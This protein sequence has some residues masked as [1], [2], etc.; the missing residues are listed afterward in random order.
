MCLWS[1]DGYVGSSEADVGAPNLGHLLSHP[2]GPLHSSISE[3]V[4]LSLQWHSASLSSCIA[5][6]FME[7]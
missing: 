7:I 4:L 2:S 3:S 6:S 5:L 1:L